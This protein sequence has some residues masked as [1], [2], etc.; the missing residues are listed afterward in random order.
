MTVE[1]EKTVEFIMVSAILFMPIYYGECQFIMVHERTH[2]QWKWL[3]FQEMKNTT[4]R[5][6][7]QIGLQLVGSNSLSMSRWESNMSDKK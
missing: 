2:R 7:S 6:T 4:R 3:L 1:K 5:E